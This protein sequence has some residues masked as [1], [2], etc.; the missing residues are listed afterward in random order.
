VTLDIVTTSAD[1][2]QHDLTVMVVPDGFVRAESKTSGAAS[3]VLPLE[4]AAAEAGALAE[5]L[6]GE[7]SWDPHPYTWST[8]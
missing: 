4:A 3:R 8:P 6:A 2:E 5:E 7:A 1:R